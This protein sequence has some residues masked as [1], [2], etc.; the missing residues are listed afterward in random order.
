MDVARWLKAEQAR[1]HD[2]SF[3]QPP[4]PLRLRVSLSCYTFG[5][6]HTG[7][8]EFAKLF[9]KHVPDCW[10][11]VYRQDPGK[12]KRCVGSLARPPQV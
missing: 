10:D 2:V 3:Q 1:F 6:P 4:D 11:L 12:P 9:A 8:G 7:N 5:A